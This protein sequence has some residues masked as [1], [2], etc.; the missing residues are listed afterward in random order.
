MPQE[1]KLKVCIARFPYAGNGACSSEIPEICD[2]LVGLMLKLKRD[3]RVDPEVLSIRYSDT[4]IT[5]TRNRAVFDARRMGV[6][7]LYMIDSDNVPDSHLRDP[8]AKPFFESSF[9]FIYDNWDRGPHVVFAPYCGPPPGPYGGIEN[10]YVFKWASV[11]TNFP[12]DAVRVAQYSRE[13]AAIMS[14]IQPAA[15][16]PTGCI[17]F[18]MRAF[19][20]TEPH[21]VGPDEKPDKPWFYYEYKDIYETEKC[22]TEDVTALRDISLAGQEL[23][24]YN[25]M[26]CNWDAWAGH[27]KPKLVGKPHLITVAEVSSK[28]RRAVRAN[29]P[30]DEQL[31]LCG[32]KHQR[33]IPEYNGKPLHVLFDADVS[34]TIR[35][36]SMQSEHDE[37]GILAALRTALANTTHGD[38]A[39]LGCHT[40]ATTLA[41]A[42]AMGDARKDRVLYALDSF[43]GLP[44]WHEKDAGTIEWAKPG[45]IECSQEALVKRFEKAGI[46]PPAI[47]PGWFKDTVPEMCLN[48][49]LAF[50]FMDGDLYDSIFQPLSYLLDN[51][52]LV[53]GAIVVIDDYDVPWFPGARRAAND[54][55]AIYGIELCKLVNT[56]CVYFRYRA[57]VEQPVHETNG[58]LI[59]SL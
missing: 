15:A 29:Q 3:P 27:M 57:P 12:N 11:E 31:V 17:L 50:V 51:D 54:I 58:E 42:K 5:M 6:D 49:K 46:D 35:A 18:D 34:P 30:A 45:S 38:V 56:K 48:S 8:G 25:P 47:V 14:G 52:A 53:D 22:S 4:P 9:N 39:E 1:R 44:E 19:E 7:V 23:Y 16:G 32:D 36:D 10:V 28:L 21:A 26:F 33:D 59:P 41:I 55:A 2:Y 24:G 13:E 37:A 20:L 43:Q 40:G